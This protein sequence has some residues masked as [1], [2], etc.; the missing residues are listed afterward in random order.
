MY[1]I[2]DIFVSIIYSIVTLDKQNH[3]HIKE[4][5]ALKKSIQLVTINCSYI[6]CY[7]NLC[8]YHITDIN[9]RIYIHIY[10]YIIIYVYILCEY[11]TPIQYLDRMFDSRMEAIHIAISRVDHTFEHRY[12]IYN[13]LFY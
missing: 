7:K 6:E 13:L 1:A 9:Y 2:K 4:L 3:A 8:L 12:N 11:R 5:E 10:V